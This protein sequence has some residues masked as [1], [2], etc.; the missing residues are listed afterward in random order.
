VLKRVHQLI[1]SFLPVRWRMAADWERRARQNAMHFIADF[2]PNWD[3]DEAGFFAS[4]LDD[5][6]RFLSEAGWTDTGNTSLLE[7]GCGVGRMTR[8]FATRFA[9]VTAVDVSPT[10]IRDAK[11]LNDH[12]KNV[13]FL[14]NSGVDLRNLPD[15]HYD[16]VLSYIV[17]QH[18]PDPEIIYGYIREALR[19]LKPDGRFRFQAR[20]DRAH[21]RPDTYSGASL[22]VQRVSKLAIEHG[23]TV[24]K[25]AGEGTAE[26]YI[27]V[28]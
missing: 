9:N 10:M 5:T 13:E 15:S 18:I 23:R 28:R 26:C 7:I 8:H 14:V 11:R 17:F 1:V 4:G 27:E 25:I 16:Y 24:H 21:A 6:N 12:L 22:D 2:R 19:V 20:N 3:G